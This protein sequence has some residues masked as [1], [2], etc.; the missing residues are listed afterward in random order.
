M[1]KTMATVALGLFLGLL[2]PMLAPA[3]EK[4]PP[5]PNIPPDPKAKLI[6]AGSILH[7]RLTSTLTSK[8]NKSGDP[9]TAQVTQPIIVDG[10]EVIP[11]AS[12][13]DGHVTYVKPSGRIHGRAELR[14]II[15]KIETPEDMVYKLSA[16][17]ED[18]NAG[19]CAK[20]G[21]DN[22]GTI[23]GCGK[24]GK[25]A[26]KSAGIAGAIG[27]GAGASVGMGH[28]IECEYYGNCGGP[29]MG[30]DIGYGAAIGAS[31]ALIYHLLKH[32]KQIILVQG[33]DLT[34]VVS[35]SVDR[36]E[37]LPGSDSAGATPAGQPGGDSRP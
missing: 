22:E 1:K 29:G 33:T 12:T 28:E 30:T 19:D 37:S 24:S 31:T 36:G 2:F 20:L 27:A 3:D 18:M 6:P 13:V 4:T 14:V 23:K 26:L 8:T 35:R 16:G 10:K 9:F 17:L 21:S 15:D 11:V 7:V 32:E 25:D 5:P 34:F